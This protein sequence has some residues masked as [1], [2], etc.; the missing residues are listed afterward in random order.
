MTTEDVWWRYDW[1]DPDVFTTTFV[2]AAHDS[3]TPVWIGFQGC[4]GGSNTV[5]FSV[6]G[7]GFTALTSEAITPLLV[8]EVSSLLLFLVGLAGLSLPASRSQ[9]P[10]AG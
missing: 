8:P 2:F 7:S 6:E 9:H 1:N 3:Y 10:T 4:C 5:R